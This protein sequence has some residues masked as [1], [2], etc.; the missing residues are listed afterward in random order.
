MLG[1]CL[2]LDVRCPSTMIS[3]LTWGHRRSSSQHLGRL[4]SRHV[5]SLWILHQDPLGTCFGRNEKTEC[6][7][8]TVL[9]SCSLESKL[10][11]DCEIRGFGIE[12][13]KN[14]NTKH[15]FY[16]ITSFHHCLHVDTRQAI[17]RFSIL[18]QHAFIS[19]F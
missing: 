9:N 8:S 19:I 13:R 17:A 15:G 6:I 11:P 2:S 5:K 14:A 12:T 16:H 1:L 18:T 4:L 7:A 10:Q 3:P